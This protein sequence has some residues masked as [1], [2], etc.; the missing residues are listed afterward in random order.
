MGALGCR[1]GRTRPVCL[2]RS[3]VGDRSVHLALTTPRG[4]W[5][6]LLA[7]SLVAVLCLAASIPFRKLAETA[8]A[9]T[10][11]HAAA[12]AADVDHE[13]E[14]FVEGFDVT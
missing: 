4:A 3:V 2:H 1:P 9:T 6:T 14:V 13:S 11:P 12:G 5:M 10:A 7:A 8:D